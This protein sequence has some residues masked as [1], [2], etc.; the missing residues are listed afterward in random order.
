MLLSSSVAHLFGCKSKMYRNVCF[1]IDYHVTK[2]YSDLS[3][4]LLMYCLTLTT[5][6]FF[7]SKIPERFSPGK[8]DYL[9]HSHQLFHV[10][11]KSD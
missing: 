9:F 10:T 5:V 6:F 11:V 8:F 2:L 1:M 4:Y 3:N 7:V